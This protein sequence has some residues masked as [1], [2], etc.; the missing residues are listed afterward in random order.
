VGV[1]VSNPPNRL[2]VNGSGLIG[3]LAFLN[4]AFSSGDLVVQNSVGVGVSNPSA[5]IEVEGGGVRFGVTPQRGRKFSRFPKGNITTHKV[6]S[7]VTSAGSDS[8][9][10]IGV[11]GLGIIA[12]HASPDGL[13]V[14][15][16]QNIICNV[17]KS[18]SLDAS[19]GAGV[20]AELAI[21]TDGYP[22]VAYRA[23][24]VL[25]FIKCGSYDCSSGNGSAF[26]FAGATAS[27]D[28]T[29]A[30]GSD[31]FPVIAYYDS[32]ALTRGLW[33]VKCGNAGCTSGNSSLK[34]DS[35]A[36]IGLY[37]TLAIGVDGVPVIAYRDGSINLDLKIVKCG[38][39][40][41]DPA[42]PNTIKTSVDSVG[43]VGLYPSLAIGADGLPIVAYRDT[44]N[45]RLKVYQCGNFNCT[46]GSASVVDGSAGTGLYPVLMIGAGGL[47]I[48]AYN[49]D[50]GSV[51]RVAK[52]ANAACSSNVNV[53][54]TNA[55]NG[56]FVQ[57]NSIAMGAD[58]LPLISYYDNTSV[59]NA[60]KVAHCGS[61][62]CVP[63]WT[64][65]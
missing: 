15:Y 20:S 54:F 33:V 17:G 13:S 9:L 57:G 65:K 19:A 58:G 26:T 24:A 43:D 2:S 36:N 7:G 14:F 49:N 46:S 25:K 50:L 55:S 37:A 8:S 47:P 11:D 63:F 31:G 51:M 32:S 10:A 29:M 52:C 41:C 40:I 45:T 30:I 39:A 3:F 27:S 23:G 53:L 61:D 18:F 60:L 35:G 4:R 22:A 1:N 16:C 62:R 21:G 12:Y 34:V 56:S 44:T 28:V 6:V 48:I 38:N 64:R 5:A 59:P 42:N